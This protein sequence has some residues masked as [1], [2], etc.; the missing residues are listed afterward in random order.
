MLNPFYFVMPIGDTFGDTF[1]QPSL[2]RAAFSTLF[3][4][5]WVGEVRAHGLTSLIG[6]GDFGLCGWNII[7]PSLFAGLYAGRSDRT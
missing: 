1:A 5:K 6:I 7:N 3:D 4:G 2:S